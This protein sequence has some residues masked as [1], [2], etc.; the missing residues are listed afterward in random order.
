[1][2]E[3]QQDPML[4]IHDPG[5]HRGEPEKR[6]VESAGPIQDRRSL[7][8]ARVAEIGRGHAGLEDLLIR[9]RR[10]RLDARG[11]VVPELADVACAG[12]RQDM[13]TIAISNSLFIGVTRAAPG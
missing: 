1:V 10:D 12:K 7:H 9:Q 5:L 6:R 3:L 2:G 11:Q 13:P 8:V 4:G